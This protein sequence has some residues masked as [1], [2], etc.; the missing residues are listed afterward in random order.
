[1]KIR[2][3]DCDFRLIRR[4]LLQDLELISTSGTI[5]VELV[6]KIELTPWRVEEVGVHHYPRLHGRSQFFRVRSLFKTLFQLTRLY[7]AVG[8]DKSVDRGRR[9]FHWMG[10]RR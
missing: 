10:E 3:I 9:T 2:D 4:E 7:V 5:C 1:V 8:I 6:R